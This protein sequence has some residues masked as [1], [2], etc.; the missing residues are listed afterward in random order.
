MVD[1]SPSERMSRRGATVSP[2]NSFFVMPER[3]L[4]E[5]EGKAAGN[6]T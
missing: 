5:E 1:E 3:T 2:L 6:T 4:L